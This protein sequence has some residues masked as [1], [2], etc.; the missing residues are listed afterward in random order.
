MTYD[1]RVSRD[2]NIVDDELPEPPPS[3]DESRLNLNRVRLVAL[4]RRSANRQ[5]Q[6]TIGV[7]VLAALAAIA[8]VEQAIAW[9]ADRP[10]WT[11][12]A[13]AAAIALTVFGI[14]LAIKLPRR[15]DV[16]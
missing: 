13:I 14:R 1:A 11:V 2:W 5:R 4:E 15:D 10:G 8:L 16:S 12:A 7:A 9:R 3:D 6:W